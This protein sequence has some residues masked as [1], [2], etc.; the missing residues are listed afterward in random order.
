M[1]EQLDEQHEEVAKQEARA[2]ET[3]HV[4]RYVLL[5]S[6]GVLT[7]AFIALLFFFG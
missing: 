2:G 6:T 4:A 1:N 5:I 7:L 3:P